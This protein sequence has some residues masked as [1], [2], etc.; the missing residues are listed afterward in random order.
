VN[1]DVID[2]LLI[3]YSAFIRYWRKNWTIMGVYNSYLYISRSPVTQSGE[4]YHTIFSLHLVY[5]WN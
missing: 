5:L 4:K 1:F 2:Q 3:R